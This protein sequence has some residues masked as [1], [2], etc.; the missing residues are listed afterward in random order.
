MA[1]NWLVQ[2]GLLIFTSVIS[3]ITRQTPDPP[4]PANRKEFTVPNSEEGQE[5]YEVYGTVL[6]PDASVVWDGDFRSQAIKK[7]AGKK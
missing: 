6:I 2:V 5:I 4:K 3:Y 1:F 7:K